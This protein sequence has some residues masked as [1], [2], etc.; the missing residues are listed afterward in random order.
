MMNGGGWCIGGCIVKMM[1]GMTVTEFPCGQR[2]LPRKPPLNTQAI[3]TTAN[4]TNTR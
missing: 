4:Q 1:A 2:L 3:T